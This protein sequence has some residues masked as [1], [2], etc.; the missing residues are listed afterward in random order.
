MFGGGGS[1]WGILGK[2][3]KLLFSSPR[4]HV[5]ILESQNTQDKCS[6]PSLLRSGCGTEPDQH[7]LQQEFN[8]K[9]RNA[10]FC[11]YRTVQLSRDCLQTLSQLSTWKLQQRQAH[12][13]PKTTAPLDDSPLGDQSL[14]EFQDLPQQTSSRKNAHLPPLRYLSS[15]PAM[16]LHEALTLCPDDE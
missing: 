10:V 14:T 13:E 4:L 3:W 11:S 6:A 7:G 15:S 16:F 1:A 2:P 9:I 12:V 8:V 5:G